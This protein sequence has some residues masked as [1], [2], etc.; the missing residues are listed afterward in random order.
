MSA[1]ARDAMTFL[2][3]YNLYTISELH[4][5]LYDYLANEDPSVYWGDANTEGSCRNT[6]STLSDTELNDQCS[7]EPDVAI[8]TTDDT[9]ITYDGDIS[10][11]GAWKFFNVIAGATGSALETLQIN[12]GGGDVTA[13]LAMGEWILDNNINVVV[14]TDTEGGGQCMSACAN[15]IFPAGTNK[16][17]SAN[18]VIG[19]HGSA[20]DHDLRG[21]ADMLVPGQ[22]LYE[23][24]EGLAKKNYASLK[25]AAFNEKLAQEI[26]INCAIQA[27]ERTFYARAGVQKRIADIGL[28]PHTITKLLMREADQNIMSDFWTIDPDLFPRFG[29]GNVT[30]ETGFDYLAYVRDSRA[31]V[32]FLDLSNIEELGF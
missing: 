9:I 14:V 12:S 32:Y 3:Y 29:I 20:S 26:G 19:W 18:T 7:S 16:A 10:V 2:D 28:E 8:D 22:F 30:I 11:A 17:I 31:D 24:I 1:P 27:R 23:E 6:Y 13:G 25:G 21:D 4:D 5:V 15:Y